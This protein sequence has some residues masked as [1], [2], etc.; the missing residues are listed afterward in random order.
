M[1]KKVTAVTLF[2]TSDGT[3]DGDLIE[4][5]RFW[6]QDDV[7]CEGFERQF[8]CPD[9]NLPHVRILRRADD[10]FVSY[11]N[12]FQRVTAPGPRCGDPRAVSL[13]LVPTAHCAVYHV[14]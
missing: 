13:P 10:A 6:A 9:R 11:R 7:V 12:R 5:H 2:I 8:L 14:N 4:I 1:R 3:T